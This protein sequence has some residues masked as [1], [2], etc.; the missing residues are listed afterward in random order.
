MLDDGLELGAASASSVN[1]EHGLE[2]TWRHRAF[3]CQM[4]LNILRKKSILPPLTIAKISFFCI[5]SKIKHSSSLV[6]QNGYLT[7]MAVSIGGFSFF[8]FMFILAE[9]LKNH[10]KS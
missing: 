7:F 3:I 5:N 10:S 2:N 4:P 6:S 8:S 9:F 1:T